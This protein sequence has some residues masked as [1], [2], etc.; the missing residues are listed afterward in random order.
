[1]KT[2]N[3]ILKIAPALLEAQKKI[4]SATKTGKNPFFHSDYATLGDV[5]EACKDILNTNGITVLQP[6]DTDTMG[7]YVETVLLH[8]SGEWISAGMKIA[9]KSETNPQD[10][11][12]AISYARRYSLQSMIFIPAIDDDAERATGKSKIAPQSPTSPISETKCTCN[13]PTGKPHG[14]L[15]AKNRQATS[16]FPND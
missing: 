3:S 14:T 16:N 2:S 6:V 1:M 9:P 12:S 5:M 10:Q 11:G 7:V 4:G 13:A 15:C 8:A